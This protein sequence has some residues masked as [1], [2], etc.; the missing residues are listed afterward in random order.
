MNPSLTRTADTQSVRKVAAASVHFWRQN[1]NRSIVPITG[2]LYPG[3][4]RGVVTFTPV[5]RKSATTKHRE[6]RV[7]RPPILL[8]SGLWMRA[9]TLQTRINSLVRGV[10]YPSGQQLYWKL[11]SDRR[12]TLKRVLT[13]DLDFQWFATGIAPALQRNATRDVPRKQRIVVLEKDVR[14]KKYYRPRDEKEV[15][16]ESIRKVNVDLHSGPGTFCSRPGCE[17]TDHT[18]RQYESE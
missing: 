3:Q 6:N 18:A 7:Q 8:C 1:L 4:P 15:S 13:S 12:P 9:I 14:L 10:P 17:T 5:S 11:E 16:H 2:K